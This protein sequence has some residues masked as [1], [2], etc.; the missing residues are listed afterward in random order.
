M[1]TY[2]PNRHYDETIAQFLADGFTI[3]GKPAFADKVRAV[4][5]LLE[6]GVDLHDIATRIGWGYQSVVRAQFDVVHPEPPVNM[7]GAEL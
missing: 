3:V 4:K 1:T 6:R 2:N 5:I 7:E